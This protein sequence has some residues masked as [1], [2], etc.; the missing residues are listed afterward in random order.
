MKTNFP[1]FLLLIFLGGHLKAQDT[2]P[3]SLDKA[4]KKAWENSHKAKIS[5]EKIIA[6]E[7]KLKAAK[8]NQYPDFGI[9]GQALYLTEPRLNLKIDTG[10]DQSE[11][12]EG[13]PRNETGLPSPSYLLLGQAN[14]SIPVFSGFKLKNA[15]KAG[16]DQFKAAQLNSQSDKEQ[17]A[18]Q[19]IKDY[20]AL[21]KARKSVELIK[22]NLKSAERR[23]TDFSNMEKNEIL[24]LNDL[25]KAKLQKSN[26][27]LA[28]AR[29][30]KNA[31]ILNYRL[32]VFL[33]LPEGTKIA[34]DTLS[35]GLMSAAPTSPSEISRPDIEALRYQKQAAEKNIKIQKGN[36]Y[37]SIALTAGY[38]A[39]DIENTLTV[40][41]ALNVGIGLSYN[42]SDIFKNKS[43][44][45]IAQSRARELQFKLD[46]AHDQVSIAI[47][48]AR[49]EYQLALQNYAVFKKSRHQA[50]EN[51]RIVKD[52][53]ENGLMETRDLLEAD[54]QR[55]QSKIDLANGKAD[56][57]LKYYALQQ[58]QGRLSNEFSN[59]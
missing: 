7:Q 32:A 33:Q 54:V 34:V 1:L 28:L 45:K 18:M 16:K 20:V 43:D 17:I 3:L 59:Q 12:G 29:A 19:T 40:S 37:P 27:E 44:V 52:K 5:G 25:L 8:N 22:E 15:V 55:L 39:A 24:P 30:K 50:A 41:R 47:E 56:I 57:T 38:L 58:A 11:E 53:F 21:Y 48:N 10:S 9:S 46:E 35:F 2:T 31:R 6:A 49:E 14:L 23:V 13:N 4:V 51:Y 42:L 26:V 36:Y